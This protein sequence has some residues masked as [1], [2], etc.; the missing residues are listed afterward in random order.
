MDGR[1]DGRNGGWNQE[2][3]FNFNTNLTGSE[4]Y[5]FVCELD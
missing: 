2:V 4:V 3:L 1:V 5:Q